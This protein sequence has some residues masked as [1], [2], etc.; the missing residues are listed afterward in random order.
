MSLIRD[1]RREEGNVLVISMMVLMLMLAIGL[2]TLATVHTQTDVSKKERERESTFNLTEAVLNAQT[3]VL[4]RLGT[5]NLNKPFPVQCESTSAP[6]PASLCPGPQEIANSYDGGSQP[7]FD[8]A[9][10]SWTTVVRDNTGGNFYDPAI[11]AQC[12][13]P[14]S[15]E[16]L[17]SRFDENGDR[18]MWVKSTAVVRGKTR[19]IVALIKVEDRPI[20]FPQYSL[21]AGFFFTTNN[22]NKE[23]VNASGSLGVGVRCDDPPPST[24][25]LG[26]STAKGQLSPA[27]AYT[28]LE[29]SN[30][31]A[32]SDADL[33]GLEDYARASGTYYES[34]PADPNGAVV[35]IKSG[36]CEFN[37]SSPAVTGEAKCCNSED[38]PG[39]LIIANG[40]LK[41]LGSITYH[42]LTYMPNQQNSSGAVVT[43][44]GT[45]LI[46]GGVTIDGPGGLAAGSSG[47]NIKFHSGAF[48]QV[49]TIGTAGVMQN[50][51]REM[52]GQ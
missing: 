45:A 13:Q 46:E 43:T 40:T 35:F 22:G 25:C 24:N 12:T 18:Q 1:M 10:T 39:L 41:L 16:C 49:H 23:I 50:T 9:G 7:D 29:D 30:D 20:I 4:G 33:Q 3:F 34:C 44:G 8:V 52:I 14:E 37:N 38:K 17:E 36:D 6:D 19:S 11:E 42:G 48:E 5:G 31:T 51:W 26:Y 47:L 27:G 21:S 15:A 28:F 2:S 32:I